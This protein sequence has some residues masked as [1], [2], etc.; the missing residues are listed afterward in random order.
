MFGVAMPAH[1]RKTSEWGK[2]P[3]ARISSAASSVGPTS[4]APV[5]FTTIAS[6]FG[7]V[8]LLD[9]HRP[10]SIVHSLLQ[11]LEGVISSLGRVPARRSAESADDREVRRVLGQRVQDLRA[12]RGL[13]Q[14]QLV[15]A[16]DMDRSHLAKIEA[17]A[18][19]PS[20][21]TLARIARGLG[22]PLAE[23]FQNS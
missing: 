7:S 9:D 20:L 10:I 3:L 8:P 6:P 22:V 13:T 1:V 5:S 16:A 23:L 2:R 14:D 12:E 4:S 15:E 21:Q 19:N 17:G 18:V 11:T